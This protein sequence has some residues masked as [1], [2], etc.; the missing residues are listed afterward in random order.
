M[1]RKHI[2]NPISPFRSIPFYAYDIQNG[3]RLNGKKR[4]GTDKQTP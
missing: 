1:A 4:T 3:T 2:A